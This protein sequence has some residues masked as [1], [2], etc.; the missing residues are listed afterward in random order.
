MKFLSFFGEEHDICPV[1]KVMDAL[2][3]ETFKKP[4][5]LPH[6]HLQ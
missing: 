6:Y 5:D 4:A 2:H 1:E 3:K